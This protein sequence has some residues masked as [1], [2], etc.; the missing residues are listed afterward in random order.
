MTDRP[1]ADE[2]PPESAERASNPARAAAAIISQFARTLKTCRLYDANNPTVVR[3]RDE[4]AT[5]LRRLLEQHGAL[6]FRFNSD[7][8]LFGEDSLYPARSRDDNFALPF[9][10]DGVRSITFLPGIEPREVDALIEALMHVTGPNPGE[11][12]LVTLLWEAQLS[13]LDLDY[14][15]ADSDV[16]AADAAA[17]SGEGALIP[18]PT[19]GTEDE[20]TTEVSEARPDAAVTNAKGSRSDDWTT[21]DDTLEVEAGFEE[22]EFLAPSEVARFQHEYEAEHAI[23][24]VTVTIAIARA[25]LNAGASEDDRGEMGRFLPRVMR[26][27]VASALWLEGH[28]ALKLLP[29]CGAATSAIPSFAQELLQPISIATTVEKLDQQESAEVADFIAF[30]RDLGDPGIDWLNLVLADS[31]NR[32]N[33]RL[34]AEAIADLCRKNPE[35]LAPWLADPRWFVVRNV[36]HIL[37]WI[38]GDQILGLLQ[39]ALRHPDPRVRQEA[40]AS[41]GQV[42]LRLARPVL[43]RMLD[44]ADSRMMSAVLH[45]LSAS[46]DPGVARLL[47]SYVQSDTF[48]ERPAEEKRAIYAALSSTG[49]DEVVPELEAELHRGNWFARNQEIHRQSIARVLARIGTPIARVALERGAQSKRGPVRKVCEEALM[50]ITTRD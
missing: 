30:A 48:E 24:N 9:Y 34:L 7:D 28:E 18:W 50:G 1:Q 13:H 44:G 35:R 14:V 5:A 39:G 37:G 19:T 43:V 21:G 32:R 47:I 4:F 12:D 31:Q 25:Y 3:F 17:E 23:S 15:P 26:Q 38:G 45:Q 11:N 40:I 42:D 46:R 2:A 6:T 41:L 33:R 8:V 10:R 27:A 49:G 22:L 16:G 29:E 20:G 36:V